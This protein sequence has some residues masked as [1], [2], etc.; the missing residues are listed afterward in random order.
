[1]SIVDLDEV[2]GVVAGLLAESYRTISRKSEDW[3]IFHGIVL[4]GYVYLIY[5]H[6]YKISDLQRHKNL[7]A[8]SLL[9]SRGSKKYCII[10]RN[11]HKNISQT[12]TYKTVLYFIETQT[13]LIQQSKNIGLCNNHSKKYVHH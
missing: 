7:V 12:T 2:G 10:H 1:M 9:K 11:T 3:D 6:I 8:R 4:D 5:R 13:Y